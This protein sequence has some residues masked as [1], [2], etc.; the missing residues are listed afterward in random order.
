MLKTTKRFF[1]LEGI[2]GSGKSTQLDLLKSAL[3][4]KGFSCLKIREP[5]GVEISERI[6]ALLLD[7]TFKGRMSD[8]AELLLYNAARAQLIHEVIE[9]ALLQGKVVLADRFSWSTY[10]YQGFGRSLGAEEVQHLTEITCGGYLPELTLVMDIE[11]ARGRARMEK[12][13]GEP[14]RLEQEK[15]DFFERVREGYLDA[16]KKY[17]EAVVAIDA[18]RSVDDIQK[19]V[20]AL[21]LSRLA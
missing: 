16:S 2:D 6:R 4:E 14:D 5:G 20:L 21:V 19:E 13:G 10:A 8:K 15:A 18:D 17:P 7:P 3:E 9:P 11:V 12:R 1:C